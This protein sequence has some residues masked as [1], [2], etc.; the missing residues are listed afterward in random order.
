MVPSGR[1][2]GSVA[3]SLRKFLADSKRLASWLDQERRSLEERDAHLSH[4]G[5]PGNHLAV[6]IGYDEVSGE[7]HVTADGHLTIHVERGVEE[8]PLLST[9]T[10]VSDEN[11]L[12]RFYDKFRDTILGDLS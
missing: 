11:G 6:S 8:E 2:S 3:K 12:K 10:A 1:R 9:S 5:S 7:M 4:W